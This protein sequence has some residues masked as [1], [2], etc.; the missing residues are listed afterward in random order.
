MNYGSGSINFSKHYGSLELESYYTSSRQA[1]DI[2]INLSITSLLEQT[3]LCFT[4]TD[5]LTHPHG[6]SNLLTLL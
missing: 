2:I 5:P 4:Y 6:L 1:G 3:F